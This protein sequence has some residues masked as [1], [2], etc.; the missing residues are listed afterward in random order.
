MVTTISAGPCKNLG[1][2]PKRVL[3]T[4]F[5]RAVY[6][7][8]VQ[9]WQ[10]KLYS[11]SYSVTLVV[12]ID[13][14]TSTG[15]WESGRSTNRKHWIQQ[16]L[17]KPVVADTV[18]NG[19]GSVPS[20]GIA[21]NYGPVELRAFNKDV[22][23][24]NAIQTLPKLAGV[25]ITYTLFHANNHSIGVCTCNVKGWGATSEFRLEYSKC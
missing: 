3:E 25:S 2:L 4:C 14:K 5:Q 11:S 23:A 1:E 12:L 6:D 18:C 9:V 24:W 15:G 13:G 20:W 16:S 21:Q 17:T 19:V 7:V 8:L 22:N 10:D